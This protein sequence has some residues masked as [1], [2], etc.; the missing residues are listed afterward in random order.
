MRRRVLISNLTAWPVLAW[1]AARHGWLPTAEEARMLVL[2][3]G[4]HAMLIWT[5][6][7]LT[8]HNGQRWS[9]REE[10][11]IASGFAGSAGLLIHTMTP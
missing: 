3:I 4:G 10:I 5:G 9:F 1:F 2:M 11:L 7:E 6:R 8:L